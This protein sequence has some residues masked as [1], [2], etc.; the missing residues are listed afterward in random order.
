M[1]VVQY[2]SDLSGWTD[3][4]IGATSGGMVNISENGSGA[5]TVTVTIPTGSNPKVFARLKVTR[6]GS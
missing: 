4:P 6:A 1:Q 5:D 3:V 2:G